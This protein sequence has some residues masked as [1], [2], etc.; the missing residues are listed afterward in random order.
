MT[1]EDLDKLKTI[2]QGYIANG[3]DKAAFVV[4]KEDG[5]WY[6]ELEGLEH[7]S[8]YHTVSVSDGELFKTEWEARSVGS[9]RW[10]R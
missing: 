10:I 7:S 9:K 5:V 3:H 2:K 8:W 1:A 6:T 4:K